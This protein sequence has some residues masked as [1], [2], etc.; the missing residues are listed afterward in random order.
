MPP[1]ASSSPSWSSSTKKSAEG[2]SPWLNSPE[3]SVC[4]ARKH[5]LD[6]KTSETMSVSSLHARKAVLKGEK[7]VGMARSSYGHRT[8]HRH[9]TVLSW[10]PGCDV[11]KQMLRSTS[12]R[13][14][15]PSDEGGARVENVP[16]K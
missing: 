15:L 9:V 7:E 14:T 16:V 5:L 12:Q 2:G 8:N 4:V 11:S 1:L 6:R 3:E 10:C 13:V